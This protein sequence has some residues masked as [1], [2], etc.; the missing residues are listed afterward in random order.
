M[1]DPQDE[2]ALTLRDGLAR[3]RAWRDEKRLLHAHFMRSFLT[4]A[5][6]SVSLRAVIEQVDERAI[7]LGFEGG[8]LSSMLA[9]AEIFDGPMT[10]IDVRLNTREDIE[11]VQLKLRGGDSLLI[12]TR[13]VDEAQLTQFDNPRL[14][15]PVKDE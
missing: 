14:P 10:F 5:I 9:G 2:R 3:L 11:A 13:E 7:K 12:S 4:G 8:A 15:G 6:T 1:K